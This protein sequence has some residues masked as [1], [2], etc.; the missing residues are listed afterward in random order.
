MKHKEDAKDPMLPLMI[1][2]AYEPR[3]AAQQRPTLDW[4]KDNAPGNALVLNDILPR[5][6]R[7]LVATNKAADL[8]AVVAF[9]ADLKDAEAR[10]Q[11]L[12]ALADALK[13]RQLAAPPQW[14]TLFPQLVKDSDPKVQQLARKLAVNFQDVEAVRR[15]LTVALD[16]SKKAGERIDA[17]GDLALARPKDAF[18]PLQELVKKRAIW[19]FASRRAAPWRATTGRSWPRTC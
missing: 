12:T 5:A 19:T 8:T 9:L 11:T 7:R 3:V 2:L 13:D 10:R 16:G 1:W 18:G 14:K 15:A 17:I 4:L 6:V